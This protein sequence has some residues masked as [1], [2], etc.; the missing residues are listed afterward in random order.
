MKQDSF[1]G[2]NSIKLLFG[3]TGI[4]ASF[5][6]WALVQEPLTTRVWPNSGSK[7]QAPGLIALV[8]AAV[9]TLVGMAYMRWKRSGY[10]AARLLKDYRR[11]LALISLMQTTSAPLAA[12]SL[13]Y[14]D[15]LTYMLAKSC[16]MLPVLLVHLLI[17]RTRIPRGKKLVALVVTLGVTTFTLGG[18]H[19]N[20]LSG[21]SSSMAGFGLLILSLF[22]DGMTNATQDE[23]LRKNREYQ[24]VAKNTAITGAHLM[25][26]LN[27]FMVLYNSIYLLVLDNAQLREAK[28]LLT[29]DPEILRY[30][31]TYAIC[32]AIGQCF[33]FFTLE[34]YG[35][36]VLVMITVTRKMISMLLS[37]AVFGKRV[38]AVQW[39]GIITVF[40][41]ISWEALSKRKKS[42]KKSQ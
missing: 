31:V 14:V 6:T 30:L 18:S 38:S 12:F 41:G 25:F 4:Y 9:A 42:Q 3:A 36:L 24:K 40:G 19:G 23:M 16:K 15:Y 33:I 22:L 28:I 8:Q 21:G 37:I 20:K 2:K 35:S 17:Y 39:L 34:E 27:F 10:G 13:Q 11:E 26:A 32:G 7:F 5:L 1:T 29:A